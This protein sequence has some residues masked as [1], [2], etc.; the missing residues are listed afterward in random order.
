M[1]IKSMIKFREFREDFNRDEPRDKSGK[2]TRYDGGINDPSNGNGVR[3]WDHYLKLDKA[4]EVANHLKFDP[5]NVFIKDGD[6]E[7]EVAGQKYHLAGSA[8]LAEGTI[9]IY[10]NQVTLE[11]LPG[12]MAHEIM[13]HKWHKVYT[14]YVQEMET[15]QRY[16]RMD[17]KPSLKDYPTYAAIRPFMNTKIA[18]KLREEDG[19]TKYSESYWKQYEASPTMEGLKSALHETLA[20]LARLDYETKGTYFDRVIRL[21]KGPWRKFYDAVNKSYERLTK[22]DN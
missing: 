5:D 9:D 6:S 7:F 22:N 12:T 16:Q 15:F 18:D 13:H 10:P 4:Q 17:T 14:T 1:A 3:P 20:E 8:H 11:S 2:W 19:A 21:R